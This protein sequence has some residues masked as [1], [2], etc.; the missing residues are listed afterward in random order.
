MELML[1]GDLATYLRQ[2]MAH[3]DYHE[4]SVAP[5]L[6]VRWAAEIA[7]GMAYLSSKRYVHRDLAARNCLVGADM[8][9]KIGG[10]QALWLFLFL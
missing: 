5:H 10:K 6:A 7:D 3:Q 9:I 2:R 4:G 1:L 8:T